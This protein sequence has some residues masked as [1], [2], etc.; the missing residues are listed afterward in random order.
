MVRR[1]INQKQNQ[2]ITNKSS[3]QAFFQVQDVFVA[4]KKNKL[5][6]LLHQI[7]ERQKQNVQDIKNFRFKVENMY[8]H[9]NRKDGEQYGNVI[10]LSKLLKL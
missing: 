7:I 8:D 6:V 3:L 1:Y 10:N 5:G 9:L 4:V 2:K